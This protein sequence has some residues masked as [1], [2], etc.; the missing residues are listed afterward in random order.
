MNNFTIHTIESAPADSQGILK[1]AEQGMG[2]V[3]NMF[4]VFA[5]SPAILEAYTTLSK[6]QTAKTAFSET[7]RQ[8]LFLSI[9]AA[10]NCEY[11]MAAH[12]AISKGNQVEGKVIDAL[13]DNT[14]IADL[15]LE[16]LRTFAL[17]VVEKRGWAGPDALAAF[18]AAGYTQRHVLEVVLAIAFKTI[19]NY[20][21]H[22]VATPLDEA[23]QPVAWSA[24]TAV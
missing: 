24:V 9:S 3:P 2:F 19:S 17:A 4:G 11:C 20:T 23:F 7:E 22:L 12:T 1:A 21:N 15:K 13:R 16:A 18:L 6:L 10:N 5:E 8:V 14:T